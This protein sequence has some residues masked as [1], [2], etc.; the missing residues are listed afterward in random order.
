M[1]V[2]LAS[3][4]R[5]FLSSFEKLL[6]L[7]GHGVVTS[8]DG[9]QVVKLVANGG[10]DVAVCDENIPRIDIN[11]VAALLSESGIPVIVL[12]NRKVSTKLLLSDLAANAFLTFPFLPDELA[13]LI[14]KVADK[15]RNGGIF[16][17]CGVKVDVKNFRFENT[18][19]KLSNGELDIL[20]ALKEGRSLTTRH[21]DVYINS[22]NNKFKLLKKDVCIEY[23]QNQGYRPVMKNG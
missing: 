3:P 7:S 14:E 16:E 21:T 15:A 2:L 4:D 5:D 13:K 18:G 22:L 10:I 8:F 23:A 9:T 11:R 12:L 19:I 6:A 17:I 20:S 1:K